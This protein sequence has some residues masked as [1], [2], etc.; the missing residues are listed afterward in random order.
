MLDQNLRE[1]F[2]EDYATKKEELIE[3]S[4]NDMVEFLERLRNSLKKNNSPIF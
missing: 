1:E 3:F 2:G 4:Y